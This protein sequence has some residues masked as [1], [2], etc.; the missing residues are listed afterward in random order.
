MLPLE[1]RGVGIE[2]RGLWLVIVTIVFTLAAL[3]AIIVRFVC[4]HSRYGKEDWTI[5]F[6]MV[7]ASYTQKPK[8]TLTLKK[9][10][11]V[12]LGIFTCFSVDHGVGKHIS[13]L[14]HDDVKAALIAFFT[15]QTLYKLS[16]DATKFSF[17]FLYLRIFPANQENHHFRISCYIVMAYV[18]LYTIASII[19]TIFQCTP[20]GR[21][22]NHSI[23]GSCINIEVFWYS[24]A[25]NNIVGN[26]LTL[27]L[28]VRKIH[29]LQI[30][31]SDK[32][33]VPT[34]IIAIIIITIE[35]R[36]S[37]SWPSSKELLEEEEKTGGQ[38]VREESKDVDEK[39]EW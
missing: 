38:L 16:I 24:N 20:V 3:T 32:G 14:P 6:S 26:I 27:S 18:L 5:A 11:S 35:Q 13:A 22:F 33:K 21:Y 28:P 10:C 23:D 34:T 9:L 1:S 36:S 7:Y 39:G 15:S 29:K 8:A 2:G 17:L 30:T 31:K 37:W 25:I 19:V 4:R 12:L